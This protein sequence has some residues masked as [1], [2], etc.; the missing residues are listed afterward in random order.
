MST[1]EYISSSDEEYEENEVY[2]NE[3]PREINEDDPNVSFNRHQLSKDMTVYNT[4]ISMYN[5]VT[6]TKLPDAK[7]IST[8]FGTLPVG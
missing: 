4:F 8:G 2:A 5:F 6:R 3:I 1:E 7:L